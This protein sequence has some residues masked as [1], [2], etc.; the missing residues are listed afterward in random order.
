[1]L[2]TEEIITF[3]ERWKEYKNKILFRRLV[4]I[5]LVLLFIASLILLF[6]VIRDSSMSNAKANSN[7]TTI[8]QTNQTTIVPSTYNNMTTV[9]AQLEETNTTAEEIDNQ[10]VKTETAKPVEPPI[11]NVSNTSNIPVNDSPKKV[12]TAEQLPKMREIIKPP[13]ENKIIIETNDIQNIE[14]LI[15]KFEASN[16]MVF[17]TMIS[18]EYFERKNYKKSLEWALR[19]NEIDSQNELSWIMFAKSQV[20]LGKI[21]D[22][23]RALEI[24]TNYA[25]DATSAVNLLKNIRSGEYR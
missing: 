6:L 1:M 15:K 20:R 3:E 11:Q 12:N 21:D 10:T 13:V 25:K 5:F 19:A 22:A 17:A 9:A 8:H 7:Q 4:A 14:E 2:K 18:E 16:N 24:Y 23:I